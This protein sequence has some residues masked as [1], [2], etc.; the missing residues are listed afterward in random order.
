MKFLAL[1]LAATLSEASPYQSSLVDQDKKCFHNLVSQTRCQLEADPENSNMCLDCLFRNG[2]IFEM[3]TWS[4]HPNAVKAFCVAAEVANFRL[5][6]LDSSNPQEPTLKKKIAHVAQEENSKKEK[7]YNPTFN[8]A[9]RGEESSINTKYGGLMK[10]EQDQMREE[11]TAYEK[12]LGDF[13][14]QHPFF[15]ETEKGLDKNLDMQ[16][17]AHKIVGSMEKST[18]A[19]DDQRK[20]ALQALQTKTGEIVGDKSKAGKVI[21]MKHDFFTSWRKF[22]VGEKGGK[23]LPKHGDDDDIPRRLLRGN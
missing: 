19:I 10:D 9:I 8:T 18:L 14:S 13:E 5:S 1:A 7:G 11:L 23:Q 17:L 12:R 16:A 20:Q 22:V 2:L 3:N 15:T 21:Q 6:I 4:C